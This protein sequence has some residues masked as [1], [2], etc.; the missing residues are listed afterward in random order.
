MSRS[1]LCTSET[2]TNHGLCRK[3]K[4]R[5]ETTR[6]FTSRVPLIFQSL[7]LS[8]T[9]HP[10]QYGH[11]TLLRNTQRFISHITRTYQS[12]LHRSFKPTGSKLLSYV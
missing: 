5:P 7:P 2:Q 12:A 3:P 1:Q 11:C 4:P 8:P 9:L 6:L 10:S